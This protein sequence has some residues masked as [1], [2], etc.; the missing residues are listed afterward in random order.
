MSRRTYKDFTK[1][2]PKEERAERRREKKKNSSLKL[3]GRFLL[4]CVALLCAYALVMNWKII[5]PDSFVAWVDDVID[6][7]TGGS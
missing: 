1:P 5:A 6:G 4:V 7:T 3:L 2:A